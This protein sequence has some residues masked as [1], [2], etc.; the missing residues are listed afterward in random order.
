M[1][2]APGRFR[3]RGSGVKAAPKPKRLND[4]RGSAASRG[5]DAD[6][7]RL[8][9]VIL[10][11]EPLCRRCADMDAVTAATMVDHIVPIEIA[12]ERRLDPD[13]LQPLCERCHRIKTAEDMAL[14]RDPSGRLDARLLWPGWLEP[15]GLSLTIVCG[16][17]GSGKS[18]LVANRRAPD[19]VVI[20]VDAIH[21]EL[22]GKET[23]KRTD[24][25]LARAMAVRNTRLANLA[26]ATGK[27]RAWFI[28]GAPTSN[29]RAKWA[30]M[31]QPVEVIVMLTPLAVLHQRIKADP[32]RNE[33][34]GWML[35]AAK[36]WW[37]KYEPGEGETAI[38]WEGSE[39]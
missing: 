21:R 7:R 36:R 8:R 19:D 29:E 1:A 11:E 38:A 31:L 30:R 26:T 27:R 14:Y 39:R 28:V 3:P 37:D 17:P 22:T 25:E 34:N 4:R 24:A 15:S 10:A 16:A 20:D 18:T 6:W 23:R 2:K 33:V 32:L 5:Y 9:E 13:N 35:A 12:P